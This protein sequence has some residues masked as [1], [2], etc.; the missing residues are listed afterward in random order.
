MRHALSIEPTP[1]TLS[2]A[3]APAGAEPAPYLKITDLWKAYGDFV[4]L[5]DISL[6]IARGEFIC[7]LGP[8]G[9]GKTT[10]LR[11]I[12]GLDLQTQGHQQLLAIQERY[13]QR[14][15][16]PA[17]RAV[18]MLARGHIKEHLTQIDLLK[19]SLG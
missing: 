1:T 17:S 15:K 7:F 2:R 13:L 19:R 12:A 5:R 9:C 4:A 6:S 16:D 8:S 14:G 3:A 18:A 11:A 10:L